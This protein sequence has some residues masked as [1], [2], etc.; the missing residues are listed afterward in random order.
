MH[1]FTLLQAKC[2]M[3]GYCFYVITANW[4]C[5]KRV[6]LLLTGATVWANT[7]LHEINMW[8]GEENG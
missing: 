4:N 3:N 1:G 2:V 7:H 8:N 6:V 5:W